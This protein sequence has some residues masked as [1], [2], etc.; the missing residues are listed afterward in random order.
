MN[1]V[2]AGASTCD[3]ELTREML[4][5]VDN[6]RGFRSREEI[7][8]FFEIFGRPHSDEED[9]TFGRYRMGRGQLFAFGVNTWRTNT[10]EMTV[11]IE[12]DGLDYHLSDNHEHVD[13]CT[14]TVMLYKPLSHTDYQRIMDEIREHGKY[15]SIP[16]K[17]NG[18]TFPVAQDKRQWD[19]E[20]EEADI[21]FRQNQDLR[22]YNQGVFVKSFYRTKYGVGG[23]VV[24]K[25]PLQVNFARNDIM[26]NCPVWQKIAARLN[27][28]ANEML[29]QRRQVTR[30]PQSTTST[31][32]RRPTVRLTE[33]DRI[34]LVNQLK[35][36]NLNPTQYKNAK[37]WTRWDRSGNVTLRTIYNACNGKVTMLP[38]RSSVTYSNQYRNARRVVENNLACLLDSCMYR[39]WGAE[40]CDDIVKLSNSKINAWDRYKLSYVPWDEL[41]ETLNS[42][43]Q[44]IDDEKL[45]LKELTVI[46]VLRDASTHLWRNY[47]VPSGSRKSPGTYRRNICVGMTPL[48]AWTD[49]KAVIGISR[50]VIKSL[51]VDFHAWHTYCG[52]IMHEALHST[53]TDR[54]HSHGND[55][56]SRYHKWARSP[57]VSHFVERCM[58]SLPR[59]SRNVGRR[60]TER[61]LQA[62][63]RFEERQTQAARNVDL[64]AEAP[65]EE[66]AST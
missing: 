5:I 21:R 45:N 34:R 7:E 32:R 39:R 6:G 24:T 25:Q 18:H 60:V 46:E 20:I 22:V 63:D 53:R 47:P 2:D 1:A 48:T 62:V 19:I 14:I 43:S 58:A 4:R 28:R 50:D 23:D 61:E 36:G 56:Y 59:I 26:D 49:G 54:R 64:Q 3:I 37:L 65:A 16:A 8:Q 10:F 17:L 57:A 31:R 15:I 44:V 29:T 42:S 11:D 35:D 66:S 30:T 55:F 52:M 33:E 12:R 9:K 41:M 51:G 27:Q 38:K 40:N 13:G